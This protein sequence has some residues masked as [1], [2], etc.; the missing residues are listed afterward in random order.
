MTDD[1]LEQAILSA[2]HR[3]CGRALSDLYALAA[4]KREAAGDID[5]A[6]FLLT[7]AYVYALDAGAASE[8]IRQ[9]LVCY[10]REE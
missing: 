4:E 2:H 6:C 9:K 5:A 3:K 8:T 7:H 10:G 1:Q